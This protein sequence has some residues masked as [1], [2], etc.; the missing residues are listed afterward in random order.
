MC[1][2]KDGRKGKKIRMKDQ[3]LKKTRTND[4]RSKKHLNLLMISHEE[5]LEN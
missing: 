4:R 1:V 2:K 5:L 3:E